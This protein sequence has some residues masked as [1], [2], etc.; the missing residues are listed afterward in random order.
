[1][2]ERRG[3]TLGRVDHYQIASAPRS[4]DATYIVGET[5]DGADRVE[6]PVEAPVADA[7][8]LWQAAAV[9]EA[10]RPGPPAIHKE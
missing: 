3:R 8:R 1:M 4:D 7:A 9:T 6:P 5:C 10:V 2:D